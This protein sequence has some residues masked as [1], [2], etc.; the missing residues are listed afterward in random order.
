MLTA[1]GGVAAVDSNVPV[2]EAFR[3]ADDVLRQGVRGISDIITVCLP[4]LLPLIVLP[5]LIMSCGSMADI[6]VLLKHVLHCMN[7]GTCGDTHSEVCEGWV[8]G[9]GLHED[10]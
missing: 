9:V 5:Q 8:L 1:A 7:H 10:A 2:G 3:V 4:A 6:N